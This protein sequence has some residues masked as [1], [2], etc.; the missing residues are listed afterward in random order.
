MIGY[1]YKSFLLIEILDKYNFL[2]CHIKINKSNIILK[3]YN[4]L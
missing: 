3:S 4:K 1:V 2:Y